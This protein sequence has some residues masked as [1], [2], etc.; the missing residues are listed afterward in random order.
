MHTIAILSQKGGTG[1]TTLALNLAMAAEAARVE[2]QMRLR[3]ERVAKWQA[4][5]KATRP[6]AEPAA[7]EPAANEL[8]IL[9]GIEPK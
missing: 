8:L 3:R 1:K 9:A 6:A 4:E 7:A 2:E 5:R